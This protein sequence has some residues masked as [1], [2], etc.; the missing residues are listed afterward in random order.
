MDDLVNDTDKARQCF[1]GVLQDNI[2]WVIQLITQTRQY[3]MGVLV[4]DT[5]KTVFLWV[6]ELMTQTRQDSI[7][8][9]DLVNDTDKTIFHG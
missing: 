9:G 2:S 8:M 4:N 5:D 7:S 3:F 1:T 6:I